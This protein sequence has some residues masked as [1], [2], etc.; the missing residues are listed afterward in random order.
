M[1][2]LEMLKF[3]FLTNFLLLPIRCFLEAPFSAILLDLAPM[4]N[5]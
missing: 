3:A 4:D 2:E 1:S 5:T